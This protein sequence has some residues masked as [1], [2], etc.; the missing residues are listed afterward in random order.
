MNHS[1]EPSHYHQQHVHDQR[2]ASTLPSL[3]SGTM[4]VSSSTTTSSV[5]APPNRC[6]EL[7][8]KIHESHLSYLN[9]EETPVK[10]KTRTKIECLIAEYLYLVPHSH[11][12]C[13]SQFS[14][15]FN[16]SIIENPEYSAYKASSAFE[17]LEKYATNLL[18]HPW[19]KEY[20]VICPYGGFYRHNIHKVLVGAEHII[21]LMGFEYNSSKESF[22]LIH[23]IIDPD[24]VSK[25][26]LECLVA[27][28]ECQIMIQIRDEVKSKGYSDCTWQ[29]IHLIRTEYTCGITDSV[30]LICERRK[31]AKLIDYESSPK[32]KKPPQN[33]HWSSNG[34]SL[35]DDKVLSSENQQQHKKSLSYHDYLYN[36]DGDQPDSRAESFDLL[37][38]PIMNHHHVYPMPPPCHYCYPTYNPSLPIAPSTS[39]SHQYITPTVPSIT[40]SSHSSTHSNQQK[41]QTSSKAIQAELYD[42]IND[43]E[44]KFNKLTLNTANSRKSNDTVKSSVSVQTRNISSIPS[45]DNLRSEKRSSYYDNVDPI[46]SLES[47]LD[48][49]EFIDKKSIEQGN[50][51]SQTSLERIKQNSLER[52]KQNSLEKT[53]QNSLEKTKNCLKMK[54]FESGL[55]SSSSKNQNN[56]QMKA[57]KSQDNR[58]SDLSSQNVSSLQNVVTTIKVQSEKDTKKDGWS[59]SSCTY[60]N[61]SSR[62]ICEMCHRSKQSGNEA[63]PLISGGRECPRCTLVNGRD[64]KFCTACDTSLAYSPTYI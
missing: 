47:D 12:F 14:N 45:T 50:K 18:M 13:Y 59:C 63:I 1:Y 34:C 8:K 22:E 19:R 31:T 48:S 32:T 5:M 64:E 62:E 15:C 46:I 57:G 60:L 61:G 21:S 39:S 2:S 36:Q 3:I 16:R 30:K 25:V 7:R 23:S 33:Y 41:V 9:M 27:F 43:V 4:L 54:G 20:H 24:K 38:Y 51:K 55:S 58:S 35:I 28:V 49:I 42:T 52:I 56:L 40:K 26:S 37:N 29:E 53:K 11:K 44:S 10:L 6:E 17:A